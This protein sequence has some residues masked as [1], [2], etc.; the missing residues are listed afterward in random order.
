MTTRTIEKDVS[1]YVRL[2]LLDDVT[3]TAR[4]PLADASGEQL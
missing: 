1:P 3:R 4:Q 2:S